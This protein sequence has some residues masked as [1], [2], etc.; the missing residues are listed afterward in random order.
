MNVG[1]ASGNGVFNGNHRQ[2]R[3]TALNG[4]ECVLEGAAGKWLHL[5]KHVTASHIRICAGLALKGDFLFVMCHV[6]IQYY[7]LADFSGN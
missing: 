3:F 6:G 4:I 7:G 1:D 2:I 5:G